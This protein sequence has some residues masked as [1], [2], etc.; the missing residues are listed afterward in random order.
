[1]SGRY[2]SLRGRAGRW[3]RISRGGN[4][5]VRLA[6]AYPALVQGLVMAGT[7]LTSR[8]D[9]RLTRRKSSSAA[10]TWRARCVLGLLI[11]SEGLEPLVEQFVKARLAQPRETIL[12]F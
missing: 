10:T 6:V 7:P 5:L 1:M 12:S 11:Y 2:R 9:V 3:H 8:A 4:L